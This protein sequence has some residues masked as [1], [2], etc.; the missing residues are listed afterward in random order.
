MYIKKRDISILLKYCS[1]YDIIPSMINENKNILFLIL[2]NCINKVFDVFMAVFVISFL[3]NHTDDIV[4]IGIYNIVCGLVVGLLA[5]LTGNWLKRGSRLLMYKIGIVATFLFM[6][7]FVFF[8]DAIVSHLVLFGALYGIMM[9]FKSFPNNLI[10]AESIS[11]PNLIKFQGYNEAMK[12]IVRIGAPVVLGFFLTMDSYFRTVEF[13]AI[14]ALAEFIVFS[15]IKIIPIATNK[16]FELKKVA[17]LWRSVP[18]LKYLDWAEF[19]RGATVDGALATLITVYAAYLFKT[20]LNLGILG[21]AFYVVSIVLSFLF[22]R[23][24]KSHHFVKILLLSGAMSILSVLLF[25]IVPDMASFIFYNFC[26][27]V[28]VAF[29]RIIEDINIIK[30]SYLPKIAPRRVEYFAMR[31][32]ILCLGRFFGYGIMIIVGIFGSFVLL[33]YLLLGLTL[34]LCIMCISCARMS[35]VISERV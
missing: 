13:L 25:I 3:F 8:R 6:C 17:H 15:Q 5:Y 18:L 30:I 24:C 22:G 16:R 33:K 14:L 2:T 11:G 9:A 27:T 12:N 35:H 26:F 7:A 10:R 4:Q 34:F 21:S 23:I 29:V 28:A 31:E 19:C 32:L 20:D 1:G